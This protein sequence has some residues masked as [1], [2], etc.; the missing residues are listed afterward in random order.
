MSS[1]MR[2]QAHQHMTQNAQRAATFAGT[3][4]ALFTSLFRH[5]KVSVT[6]PELS[7]GNGARALQHISL[8][9]VAGS[10][11]VIGHVNTKDRTAE[12]RSLGLLRQIN[13]PRFGAELPVD[14]LEYET[15][16]EKAKAMLTELDFAVT[17][18]RTP[19]PDSTRP[20]R[21]DGLTD[22]VARIFR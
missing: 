5:H 20:G 21:A 8:T 9:T 4:E 2:A 19:R 14:A 22:F 7:T 11:I 18:T 13:E 6:T 17:I 1:C 3:F 12:L 10:S 16:L 15:F